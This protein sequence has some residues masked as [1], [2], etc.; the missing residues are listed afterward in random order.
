MKKIAL[1]T[2]LVIGT[3]SVAFAEDGF[4]PNLAN[5]YPA[6]AGPV[7]AAAQTFQSAPV[8]MLRSRNVALPAGQ[9]RSFAAQPSPFEIDRND[10]AS[11]PYAGGGF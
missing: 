2:A 10:R 4:D 3:A 9:V 6:Y 7:A 1:I 8:R 5:R 11:S